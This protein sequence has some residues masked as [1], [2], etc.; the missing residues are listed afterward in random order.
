[1]RK[2]NE[3]QISGS[4]N[5]VLLV[6]SWTHSFSYCLGLLLHC[7]RVKSCDRD[8]VACK[9]LPGPSQEEHADLLHRPSNLFNSTFK[10]HYGFFKFCDF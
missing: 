5:A 2:F 8:S 4:T 1:M 6:H 3:I 10:I 9:V 7:S